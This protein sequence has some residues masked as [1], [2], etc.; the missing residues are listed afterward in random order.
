[1]IMVYYKIMAAKMMP[2]KCECLCVYDRVGL[3]RYCVIYPHIKFKNNPLKNKGA[4]VFTRQKFTTGRPDGRTDDRMPQI[5][6]GY[7]I[8]PMG[9]RPSELKMVN[10][11]YINT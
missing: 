4:R 3:G 2:G 1:M 6:R 8:S 11:T 10:N 9:L 5:F 7:D